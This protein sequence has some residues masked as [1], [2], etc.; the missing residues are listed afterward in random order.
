MVGTVTEAL[1]HIKVELATLPD[2]PAILTLCH[3]VGDQ[4]R[5]RL[6]DPVTTIPLCILQILHGNTACSHLPRLGAHTLTASAFCQA[7][8]RLPLGVWQRV[9]R[10]TAAVCEPTTHDEGR[11]WGHR[12]FLIDGSSFSRPDTPEWHEYF[13]QP[14]G[15]RPGCGCPVAHLRALFHAGTGVMLEVLAA[16]WHTHDMAQVAAVHTALPP[17]DVL[18]GDRAFCAF[19]PLAV[20]RQQGFHAVLRASITGSATWPQ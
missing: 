18:V 19:V 16:P 9:L 4:W 2:A 6:L 13:G 7:R 11:W 14:T 20:L 15:Q 10:Q 1:R 5:A 8:P 3:E 12:T 17:G